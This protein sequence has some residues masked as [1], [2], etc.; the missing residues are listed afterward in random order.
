[1]SFLKLQS[2][3]ETQLHEGHHC[4]ELTPSP[5]EQ[6]ST[7]TAWT[8]KAEWFVPLFILHFIPQIPL[9]P[10]SARFQLELRHI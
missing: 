8:Q 2:S 5:N 6:H 9:S 1:M 10:C 7:P 4:S 3:P